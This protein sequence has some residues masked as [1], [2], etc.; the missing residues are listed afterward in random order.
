MSILCILDFYVGY[1]ALFT[2]WLSAVS[3]PPIDVIFA[4]PA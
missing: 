2:F 4:L 1:S 3:L